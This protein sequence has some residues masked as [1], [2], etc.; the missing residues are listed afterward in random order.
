MQ[1]GWMGS[2][3]SRSGGGGGAGRELGKIAVIFSK[4]RHDTRSSIMLKKINM[5]PADWCFPKLTAKIYYR[6]ITQ[7][8]INSLYVCSLIVFLL[9][10]RK[11]LNVCRHK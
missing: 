4:A 9:V 1:C 3:R 11:I 8:E 10:L 7:P 6:N 2:D 5:L